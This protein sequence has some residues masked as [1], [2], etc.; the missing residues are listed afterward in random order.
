MNVLWPAEAKRA[1]EVKNNVCFWPSLITNLWQAWN[2]TAHVD[3][4]ITPVWMN[5]RT[6][7]MFTDK[8]HWPGLVESGNLQVDPQFGPSIDN[9]VYGNT[10]SG[11][12]LFAHF[13]TVRRNDP[14][15]ITTYGYQLETVT[16]G[17]WLPQWPLPEMTDMQYNNIAL[18]TGGTDGRPIG[19]PYWFTGTPTGVKPGA[20]NVTYKF[21]LFDAYPNPFNPTTTVKFTLP[22]AGSVSL[23]VYNTLGQLVKIVA[24]GV[25]TPAGEHSY[26]IDMGN[27]S[28]GVY[29]YTLSQGNL[30]LS[31]KMMLLK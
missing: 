14:S 23:K 25:H 31:K 26:G 5:T 20:E 1:I 12:G 16:G 28:S 4:I 15:T 11:D 29:I 19:D 9:V 24:D 8:T 3:T 21:E 10:G 13:T 2:D 22:K 17:N 7:G 6:T 18:K 27:L 30:R